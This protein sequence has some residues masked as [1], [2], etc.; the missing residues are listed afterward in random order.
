MRNKALG[1]ATTTKHPAAESTSGT[2]NKE[3]R[4]HDPNVRITDATKKVS[5][6]R[7]SSTSNV[8]LVKTNAARTPTKTRT[9]TSKSKDDA[10]VAVEINITSTQNVQVRKSGIYP[11]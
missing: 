3:N 8:E 7:K 2:T 9:V 11:S 4:K 1:I 10:D 5:S 6:P